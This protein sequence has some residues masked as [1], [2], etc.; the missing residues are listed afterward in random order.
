MSFEPLHSLGEVRLPVV[1]KESATAEL[2][3]TKKDDTPLA[4]L[5]FNH[6]IHEESISEEEIEIQIEGFARGQTAFLHRIDEDNTN[7]F[8]AW[9]SASCPDYPSKAQLGAM[10]DA[11]SLRTERLQGESKNS[12]LVFRL[13]L[14]PHTIVALDIR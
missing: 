2:L 7:A 8:K 6:E 9:R 4:I 12:G 10:A 1:A 5:A 13:R 14:P 11:S 3:S